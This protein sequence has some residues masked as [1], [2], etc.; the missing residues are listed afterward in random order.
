M[1]HLEAWL[2]W[3]LM[4]CLGS[5]YKLEKKKTI[6]NSIL[7]QCHMM[8]ENLNFEIIQNVKTL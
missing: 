7:K 5:S 1:Q 3:L 4:H 2:N 6:N 8:S